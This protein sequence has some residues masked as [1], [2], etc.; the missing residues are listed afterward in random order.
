MIFLS[1]FGSSPSVVAEVFKLRS[2]CFVSSYRESINPYWDDSR[3]K[4][5]ILFLSC[6]GNFD[7]SILSTE[8]PLIFPLYCREFCFLWLKAK[9]RKERA[10]KER[11]ERGTCLLVFQLAAYP[12][13]PASDMGWG[14]ELG[15]VA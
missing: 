6:A 12:P 3:V 10:E 11:A 13:F 15:Q 4:H 1:V 8:I 9:T 2:F 5:P 7:S 14:K